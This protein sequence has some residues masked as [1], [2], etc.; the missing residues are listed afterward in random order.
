MCKSFSKHI[1][2]GAFPLSKCLF[3][4]GL[5]GTC[6]PNRAPIH[7]TPLVVH[8]YFVDY[9]YM[10]III[11]HSINFKLKFSSVLNSFC[12]CNQTIDGNTQ[13]LNMYKTI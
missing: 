2:G 6:P 10:L 13:D 4:L 9:T 8:V 1:D 7:G 3:N 11:K 12:K 5:G